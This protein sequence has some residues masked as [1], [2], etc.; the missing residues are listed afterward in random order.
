VIGASS[1]ARTPADTVNETLCW[2]GEH[3]SS[4]TRFIVPFYKPVPQPNK[5][6]G[7]KPF[8]KPLRLPFFF[9]FLASSPLRPQHTH[10][11]RR[12]EKT[13]YKTMASSREFAA[14][15]LPASREAQ[16]VRQYSL[17]TQVSEECKNDV[18]VVIYNL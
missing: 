2:C 14:A 15:D 4:Q 6:L 12:T 3:W 1:I 18:V 17:M 8:L 11:A 13:A 10:G 5:K 16:R 9:C 7:R